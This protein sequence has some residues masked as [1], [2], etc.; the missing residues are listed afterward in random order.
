MH[1]LSG[2]RGNAG[3]LSG[4]IVIAPAEADGVNRTGHASPTADEHMNGIDDFLHLLHS[5]GADE[6]KLHVGQ[7]PIIVLDGEPKILEEP[8]LTPE[9]TEHILQSLADTRQRRVLR[10][11]GVVEFIYTFR[12]RTKFVVRA[13]LDGEIVGIDI[14]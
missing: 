12:Q 2:A 1:A 5:D 7:P 14:H 6:L 4:S 13:T 3:S 10:D 8:A 9:N 11:R